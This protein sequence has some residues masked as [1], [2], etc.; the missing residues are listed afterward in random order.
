MKTLE[1]QV[2]E[3]EKNIAREPKI[4]AKIEKLR[5]KCEPKSIDFT[6]D[7]QKYNFQ[8]LKAQS[9]ATIKLM[10]LAPVIKKYEAILDQIQ[11]DKVKLAE[12]QAKLAEFQA[13]QMGIQ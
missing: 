13:Q 8:R 7:I 4:I 11:A 5:A 1:K 10:R 6:G 12:L 3:L 2:K 9:K